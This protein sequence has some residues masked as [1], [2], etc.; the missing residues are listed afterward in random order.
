ME[1]SKRREST[2][3]GNMTSQYEE[4][5]TESKKQAKVTNKMLDDL[6]E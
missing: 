2:L 6:K 3:L 1:R 5:L 4:K